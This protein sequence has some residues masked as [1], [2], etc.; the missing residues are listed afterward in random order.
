[1]AVC[2]FFSGVSRLKSWC[3]FGPLLFSDLSEARDFSIYTLRP[4][5][6]RL[7]EEDAAFVTGKA[8]LIHRRSNAASSC[9]FLS[10]RPAAYYD[11]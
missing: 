2:V 3:L 4:R 11:D 6:P 5:K 8:A 1:M 9:G 7:L 10:A